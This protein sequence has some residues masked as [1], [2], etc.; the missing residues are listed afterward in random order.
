MFS[1]ENLQKAIAEASKFEFSE[2]FVTRR[3]PVTDY[4]NPKN[5]VLPSAFP[6][7]I[8]SEAEILEIYL[9]SYASDEGDSFDLYRW[10]GESFV[11]VQ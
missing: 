1:N 7:Y 4:W 8:N 11:L 3:G 2:I 9:R 6:S 5:D 10:N